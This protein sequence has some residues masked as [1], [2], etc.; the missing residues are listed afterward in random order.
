MLRRRRRRRITALA[1][2]ALALVLITAVLLEPRE[3]LPPEDALVLRRVVPTP[4]I[5]AA[6]L[7]HW[8]LELK[9]GRVFVA[10]AST[11]IATAPGRIVCIQRRI[12]RLTG[13]NAIRIRRNG[14]C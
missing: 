1:V 6:G 2:L 14:A 9:D 3:F 13:H 10:T 4:D 7:Q 11:A 8:Q 12:G 5:A